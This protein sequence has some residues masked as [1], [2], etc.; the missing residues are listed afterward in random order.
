ME[1]KTLTKNQIS[2]LKS[3]II[4]FVYDEIHILKFQRSISETQEHKK[5]YT[6]LINHAEKSIEYIH[7]CKHPQ[8]L[9]SL[10]NTYIGGKEQYYVI[11]GESIYKNVKKWDTEKGY[12]QF[13][14]LEEEA[15]KEYQERLQKQKE[16]QEAMAKAKEEGKKVEFVMK[17]G[18]LTPLILEEPKN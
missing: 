18:K 17:D 15:Q 6:K 7:R 8:I 4:G 16:S 11:M 5:T 13:L 1:Q 14:V 9:F 2:E 12:K 10:Y 3:I